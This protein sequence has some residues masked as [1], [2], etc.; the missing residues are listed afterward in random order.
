[1]RINALGLFCCPAPDRRGI[2][3][4][5]GIPAT[6]EG[7]KLAA[8]VFLRP[9]A[10]LR[11]AEWSEFDLDAALWTVPASR[12]KRRKYAKENGPPHLVQVHQR[13]HPERGAVGDGL[14][15]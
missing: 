5:R 6:R 8:L 10:E 12:M 14:R 9:G 4:Y 13:E 15:R 3:G 11:A 2:D 7:L 1:L